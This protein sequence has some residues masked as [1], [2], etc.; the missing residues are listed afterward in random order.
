MTT[1][2]MQDNAGDE[3][4]Y[5][6]DRLPIAGF[7]VS[8]GPSPSRPPCDMGTFESKLAVAQAI[9]LDLEAVDED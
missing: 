1:I 8:R 4:Q 9:A 5:E 3:V 7:A 2:K 6:V